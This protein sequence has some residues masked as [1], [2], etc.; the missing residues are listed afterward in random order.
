MNLLSLTM[1]AAHSSEMP[2]CGVKK[3]KQPSFVDKIVN[4]K[5]KRVKKSII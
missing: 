1:G 3:K 2:L 5:R 4:K